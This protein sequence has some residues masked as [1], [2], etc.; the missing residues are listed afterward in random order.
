MRLRRAA[1]KIT[2]S[3]ESLVRFF[4]THII[5]S[6]FN[7]LIAAF[8]EGIQTSTKL[9]LQIAE[10][11]TIS[12]RAQ[13]STQQWTTEIRRLSDEF[14][15]PIG[16]VAEATYETLSNQ[17]AKGADATKFLREAL[18]FSQV[19]VSSTTDSV[20]LLSS[21]INAYNIPA[22]RAGDLSATFFKIID[23]GRVRASEMAN[24]F[25]RVANL[26]SSL[27]ISLEE[28]GAAITVLTRQGVRYNEAFTLINN[29]ATKLLKP[30]VPLVKLFKEWG[31]ANGEAAIATFGFAGTL[32]KLE[33]AAGGSDTELAS[34]FKD[35]RAVRGVLG[36]TGSAFK[37]FAS[38]LKEI[39][40]AGAEYRKGIDLIQQSTG[41]KFEK[42]INEVKNLF[43]VDISKDFI[44]SIVE[45]T[46][47]FGSLRDNVDRFLTVGKLG[48]EVFILYKGYVISAEIATKLFNTTLGALNFT[49]KGLTGATF[50]QVRAFEAFKRSMAAS[51]PLIALTA[52]V[53]IYEKIK[54]NEEEILEA[55]EKA[56]QKY[57]ELSDKQLDLDNQ[58][59][60]ATA[61]AFKEALD[62]Q[63]SSILQYNSN[64]LTANESIVD[65]INDSYKELAENLKNSLDSAYSASREK[66]N[67]FKKDID[68]SKKEIERTQKDIRNLT[69]SYE[70]KQFKI[71]LDA[72]TPAEQVKLL[73]TRFEELTKKIAE[74]K[75]KA[76]IANVDDT[77][78]TI[79][80][81]YEEQINI[82]EE[83]SERK[84]KIAKEVTDL[85]RKLEE[86]NSQNS[87][88]GLIEEERSQL[89][90][91]RL[92]N[93]KNKLIGQEAEK[94]RELE[95]ANRAANSADSIDDLQTK[96]QAKQAELDAI[97]GI[98]DSANLLT[99]AYEAQKTALRDIVTLLQQQKKIADDQAKNAETSFQKQ[100]DDITAITKFSVTD[101]QGKL[102]FKTVDEAK[103]AFD[104]LVKDAVK[105]G[106]R[107][108]ELIEKYA[109]E[110][111][112][113]EAKFIALKNQNELRAVQDRLIKEKEAIVHQRDE[114]E[115]DLA[116]RQKK[117]IDSE[118]QVFSIIDQI[119]KANEPG[120]F[121]RSNLQG[122]DTTDLDIIAQ[123]IKNFKV[124]GKL[125]D[126]K[127]IKQKVDD[128]KA[129][130]SKRYFG[131]DTDT[132]E[133]GD[134]TLKK[135]LNE[136]E[137]E[138]KKISDAG[139]KKIRDAN[140]LAAFD[141]Q[142][143]LLQ[144]TLTQLGASE[145]SLFNTIKEE[146]PKSVQG[147]IQDTQELIKKI[148]ELRLKGNP[149]A[150]ATQPT[151]G[152]STG[153]IPPVAA[154]HGD[155][156]PAMIDPREFVMN[157]E[158]S[159]KFR[160]TLIAMNS[161]RFNSP[162]AGGINIG[163]INLTIQST[164]TS[165]GDAVETAKAI[166]NEI[167][168]GSIRWA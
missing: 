135:L 102:A 84:K 69:L 48:V 166:R 3:W 31:V 94:L 10:I 5:Y 15:R 80:K 90:A 6:E 11:Q 35:I 88:R 13:L 78:A 21:A 151:K 110:S 57:K 112:G 49:T 138:T 37:D 100:K 2:I 114:L 119:K 142:A 109:Q 19:T 74:A 168:R 61:K 75:A 158:A 64:V 155:I 122:A 58:A 9:S 159:A 65:D 89:A 44:K 70:Q 130:A 86:Q 137:I 71:K 50:S 72:A 146:I 47:T 153:Y 106:L 163:D 140:E 38:D 8:K 83:L 96:L 41:F 120:F 32:K 54:S 25:G 62:N 167:R 165:Q 92:K 28:T 139:T 79:Q 34:M 60:D 22:E 143:K 85:Q 115:K 149:L 131:A 81:D 73:S 117:Q 126:L 76:T 33:E 150:P 39:K 124:S 113:I 136:I 17:I 108:P 68:D 103:A 147:L 148:D 23:L 160:T 134:T 12:Q 132:I 97:N 91:L 162:A 16:D 157:P 127:L 145:N 52:A 63:F 7:K 30:T 36:L 40:N 156:M 59:R 128:F 133:I 53:A 125:D 43:A 101:N 95:A 152:F 154:A 18:L 55:R 116:E 20:N 118:N 99:T 144:T 141:A 27:G 46:D 14:N 77:K 107:S 29:I 42:Q 66:Y 56:Y 123:S 93:A 164:G 24:T 104:K 45:L 105:D 129:L 111:L 67:Q 51:F 161:G 87:R 1:L 26:T 98:K 4:A 82:A 121:N